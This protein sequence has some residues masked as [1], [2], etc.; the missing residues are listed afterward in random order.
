MESNTHKYLNNQQHQ[1]LYIHVGDA[2]IYC[3][4]YGALK[5]RPIL[6]FLHGNG[7]N[8]HYF[9]P[10]IKYFINQYDII[11]IDSRAH[12]LS[13][14][15][16]EPLNF[17]T[18]AKD[19]LAVLNELQVEKINI[20]GF[21]DGAITALHLALLEPPRIE[22]M[23]LAGVN[24]NPKGL[25][26]IPRLSVRLNYIRLSILSWISKPMKAQKEIWNLM[27]NHPNLTHNELESITIPSLIITGEKDRVSQKHNDI[28][29]Q[30]MKNTQRRIIPKGDH[31]ISSKMPEL[32]NR[33][34]E[35]FLKN[36]KVN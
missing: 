26:P 8:L 20:I 30:I 16:T 9:E 35:E 25:L 28:L 13:K 10:Q 23:V 18:M 5:N 31:F 21:S 14:R 27:V 6:V 3:E 24:Y 2:D 32:F 22:S 36:L 15:G 33:E 34:V 1:N 4:T 7:E 11:E 12:G 19:V 29:S 17:W